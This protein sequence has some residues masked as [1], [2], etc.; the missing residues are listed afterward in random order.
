M[1]IYLFN[2]CHSIK[3]RGKQPMTICTVCETQLTIN[4]NAIL[5]E[6]ITCNECGADLEI[7]SLNPPQV[8]EAPK[9][10]EDWGE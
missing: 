6:I 3:T 10:E 4:A 9:E 7:V 5:N 2:A 1:F 8:R